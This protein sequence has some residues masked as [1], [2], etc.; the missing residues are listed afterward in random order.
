MLAHTASYEMQ[1]RVNRKK[2]VRI[3]NILDIK[4]PKMTKKQA[5]R[6]AKARRPRLGHR[7]PVPF[8]GLAP[9]RPDD[10]MPVD[11]AIA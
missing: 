1:R 11:T 3:C 9:L 4:R 10:H 2:V 7:R 5:I 8:A 6:A